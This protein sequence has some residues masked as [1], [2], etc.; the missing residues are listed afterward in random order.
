MKRI[1]SMAEEPECY[2]D[3]V[4]V[5]NFL[6]QQI[7]LLSK[8]NSLLILAPT[9]CSFFMN[10]LQQNIVK[11]AVK[12]YTAMWVYEILYFTLHRTLSQFSLRWSYQMQGAHAATEGQLYV[13]T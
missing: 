7:F 4:L 3:S 9:K 6:R 2:W 5:V 10:L 13:L 1:P 8:I 12:I 11:S